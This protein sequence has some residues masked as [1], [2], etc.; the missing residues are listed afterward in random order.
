MEITNIITE[1]IHNK[2]PISFSK[3]GDGEYL[4][5]NSY[6]GA[7]CDRDPYTEKKKN[8]L[9]DSFRYMVNEL[10]N[11]YIGVCSDDPKQFNYWTGLTRSKI[12]F[13]K[14]HTIIMD[15]DHVNDKIN[16][17]KAIKFSTMKKIYICNPLMI[18]AKLLLNIDYM[19][20]V[21]FNNWFDTNFDY[22]L[23]YLKNIIKPDEQYIVITSA[24]M[25]AKI[26]ICE[27]SKIF[28]NNIY[29]DFGSAIDKICTKRTSRGWEP[30]YETFMEL[31]KDLINEDEW[32]NPG[33]NGIYEQAKY[34][35]GV[36]IHP[37]M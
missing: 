4:C 6:L 30:S 2:T 20:H 26:L 13:S 29:L 28:P 32:N 35:L 1:A 16:L 22:Y 15:N 10:P 19:L 7:N 11:T 17:Y 27:L 12:N 24:G 31:L 23:K 37:D 34:K 3:Y 36:H 25:G 9:I 21:P 18:K 14:Y 8:G 5:A 33:F